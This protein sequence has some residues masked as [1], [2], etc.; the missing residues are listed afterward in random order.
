MSDAGTNSKLSHLVA[1]WIC[2]IIVI[3]IILVPFFPFWISI[4]FLIPSVVFSIIS[5]VKG[6]MFGGMLLFY[7]SLLLPI[8]TIT[9][10]EIYPRIVTASFEAEKIIEA[11]EEAEAR[12]LEISSTAIPYIDLEEF[13]FELEGRIRNNS[14]IKLDYINVKLECYDENGEVVFGRGEKLGFYGGIPPGGAESFDFNM[15]YPDKDI[16]SCLFKIS[17]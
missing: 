3:I 10:V 15:T 6:K 9:I 17:P 12:H 13:E 1:G 8:F 11:A 4:P 16:D 2:V 5:M 14:D 7:V